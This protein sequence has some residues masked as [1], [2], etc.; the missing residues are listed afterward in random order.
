VGTTAAGTARSATRSVLRRRDFRLLL[1]SSTTSRI[2]DLLYIV[3]LVA[4][5]YGQTQSA[6]WVSAA[7]LGRFVP[8]VVLSPLAGVVADRYERRTAMAVSELVQLVAMGVLTAVA[9]L[10]GPA[11]AVVALSTVGAAAAT[12]NQAA[13]TALVTATVP[14]DELTAANSLMSTVSTIAFTAGPALGG[15][16]LIA[17]GSTVAFGINAA[18]F[19][20]SAAFLLAVRTRSRPTAAAEHHGLLRE[21]RD[22]VGEF[23]GNRTVAVLVLCVTAATVVFGFE[24]VALVLVSSELLGTGE[25]GLGWLMAASG[26]GGV[27]G[28]ALTSRLAAT[29]RPRLVIAVLTLFTGVPLAVLAGV[30]SPVLAY[31][32]LVVEGV[33]IVA[34]EVLVETALQRGIPA[35]ALGRVYGLVLSL[36]A[37]GTAVGTAVAPVAI[38]GLGL[39]LALVLVGVAPVALAAAGLAALRTFDA[40]V[41]GA[42]RALAPRVAVLEQLRMLEGADLPV[43]ERLAEAAVA[44]T[45]APGTVVIRQGDPADDLFVLVAGTLAVEHTVDGI[46][47]RINEMAAPD[48]LGEIGLVQRTPRTAT[49]TASSSATLWRIPGPLFLEAATAQGALSSSFAGAMSTRLARTPGLG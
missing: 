4:Y 41:A 39:R 17:S 1:A 47:R 19:A 24:L 33:A 7:T 2:G 34:Q 35:D 36:T 10:S 40:D 20:V 11:L 46:M 13:A 28:A 29:S 6:A 22:G 16:L 15:L 18:T 9:A 27:L 42:G 49:V 5:V 32:V 26:V 48:Y 25:Q 3:A 38:D 23:V 45:V 12:M 43:L 44:E 37:I 21:L 31:V 30:G 14:E 8:G